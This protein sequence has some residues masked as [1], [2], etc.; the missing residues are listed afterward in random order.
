MADKIISIPLYTDE[1]NPTQYKWLMSLLSKQKA[2]INQDYDARIA[3]LDTERCN[4]IKGI[5]AAVDALSGIFFQD[6]DVCPECEGDGT[7]TDYTGGYDDHGHGAKCK[8]C[9]GVGFLFK[10]ER[11]L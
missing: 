5:N 2:N 4:H 10:R 8:N 7:V 3:A 6:Y 1:I 11:E 9:K